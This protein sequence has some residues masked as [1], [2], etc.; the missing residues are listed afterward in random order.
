VGIIIFLSLYAYHNRDWFNGIPEKRVQKKNTPIIAKSGVKGEFSAIPLPKKNEKDGPGIIV[1]VKAIFAKPKKLDERDPA[2]LNGALDTMYL[3]LGTN[4]KNFKRKIIQKPLTV[5]EEKVVVA[6]G[7][8]MPELV[9]LIKQ[10]VEKKG[11]SLT[12]CIEELKDSSVILEVSGKSGLVRRISIIKDVDR[13]RSLSRLAI[14]V[15]GFGQELIADADKLFS[16]KGVALTIGIIPLSP[17]ADH[18]RTL[19]L[20]N[21]CEIISMLPMESVPYKYLG[22]KA[23]YKRT[24]AGKL[25]KLLEEMD[26]SIP[27]ANGFTIYGGG[28][29]ILEDE[30]RHLKMIFTYIQGNGK[31]FLENVSSGRSHA[32]NCAKETEL[33]Y[34]KAA[35]FIDGDLNAEQALEE[36]MRHTSVIKKTGSGVLV[37]RGVKV[38]AAVVPK[39]AENLDNADI[40]TVPLSSLFVK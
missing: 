7:R 16:T 20:Q 1:R 34:K 10:S 4:Q 11:L 9:L 21:G 18:Y 35:A 31:F 24:D 39:L 5:V 6:K 12:G 30:P 26:K 22:D 15:E 25:R 29:R 17:Q 36:V 23:I 27:E 32:L 38:A 3:L 40:R 28:L 13:V 8:P 33:N 37:F 2:L 14:V 19:A